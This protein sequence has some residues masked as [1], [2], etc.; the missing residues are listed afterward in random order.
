MPSGPCRIAFANVSDAVLASI[1]A[2]V[3]HLS[4]PAGVSKGKPQRKQQLSPVVE[5]HPATACLAS[6][7]SLQLLAHC[8]SI[9]RS[10]ALQARLVKAAVQEAMQA[11]KMAFPRHLL[12][13]NEQRLAEC[14]P[15]AAECVTE[16]LFHC[17]NESFQVLVLITIEQMP[18]HTCSCIDCF[19]H[20]PATLIVV[21]GH[22]CSVLACD[23]EDFEARIQDLMFRTTTTAAADAGGQGQSAMPARLPEE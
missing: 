3:V 1:T 10:S 13:R 2:V 6:S 23:M 14:I 8:G 17:D 21:Q 9:R 20:V 18:F 16:L 7:H 15:I 11:V 5:V 12:S 19:L 4:S 22:L